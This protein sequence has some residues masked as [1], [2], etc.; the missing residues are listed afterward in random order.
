MNAKIVKDKS[1]R[2]YL[3]PERCFVV[4]NYSDKLVSIAKARVKPGVTT[5]AHHLKGATEIYIIARG[6]GNVKVGNLET[7]KVVAGDVVVIPV[8]VSQKI[9]NTG[10]T[11]LVFHC[12]C[13]PRFT[14]DCY[15]NEEET[16]TNLP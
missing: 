7:T 10:K 12:I 5:I 6:R 9:T 14:Q 8:G 13:T 16:G 2:E 15:C 3:T 1:L 11:D 4:E